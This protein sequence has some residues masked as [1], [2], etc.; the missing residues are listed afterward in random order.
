MLAEPGMP[1]RRGPGRTIGRIMAAL[2]DMPAADVTTSQV[3]ALLSAHAK[4]DVGARSVNKHRQVV[5]TIFNYRASV[6]FSVVGASASELT[7][8]AALGSKPATTRC[9]EQLN[10]RLKFAGVG[11]RNRAL[12]TRLTLRRR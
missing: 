3:E 9:P 12:I 5:A 7:R 10:V 11:R 1:Y 4:E 8:E 6:A 2:G